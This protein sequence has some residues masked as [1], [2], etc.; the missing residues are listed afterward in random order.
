MT[1]DKLIYKVTMTT[2]NPSA[3]DYGYFSSEK[4]AKDFI[5]RK[6][7]TVKA[8]PDYYGETYFEINSLL[9]DIDF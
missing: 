3:D 5:K 8:Q 9:I 7:I 6:E 2:Q 1:K 4:K